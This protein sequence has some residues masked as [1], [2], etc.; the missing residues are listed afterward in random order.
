MTGIIT[1]PVNTG[2]TGHCIQT[3]T[4]ALRLAIID[5]PWLQLAWTD[6]LYLYHSQKILLHFYDILQTESGIFLTEINH[7]KW[8]PRACAG[9]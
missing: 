2:H 9:N 6:S 5:V 1:S 4:S 3:G 8:C 7:V